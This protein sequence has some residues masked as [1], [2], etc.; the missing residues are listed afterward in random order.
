MNWRNFRNFFFFNFAPHPIEIKLIPKKFMKFI[1][2]LVVK[3]KV[4]TKKVTEKESSKRL[5]VSLFIEIKS[6]EI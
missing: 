1:A 4:V 2:Q 6:A 5:N 3:L